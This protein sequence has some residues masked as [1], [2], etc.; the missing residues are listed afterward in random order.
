[1]CAVILL[2]TPTH[3]VWA[4]SDAEFS[5]LSHYTDEVEDFGVDGTPTESREVDKFGHVLEYYDAIVI[6]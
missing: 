5:T 4:D 1:M 2:I 6:R 3:Q